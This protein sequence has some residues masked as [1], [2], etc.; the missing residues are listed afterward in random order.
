MTKI[1]LTRIDEPIETTDNLSEDYPWGG[2]IERYDDAEIEE[3]MVKELEDLSE[4]Q[5][6]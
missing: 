1:H 4:V 2:S 5:E 3:A 6:G